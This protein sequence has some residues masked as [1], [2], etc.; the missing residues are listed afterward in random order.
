[1]ALMSPQAISS[2]IT[3]AFAA[4]T[5][6]DTIA[7]TSGLVLY[8]KNGATSGTVTIVVPGDQVYSGTAKADLVATF[9]NGERAFFISPEAVDPATGLVTVTFSGAP[10]TW[11][12]ALLKV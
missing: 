5:V 2:V 7:Y 9:A 10:G 11:T 6:S 3:P 8:V 1:M 12:A 4:P